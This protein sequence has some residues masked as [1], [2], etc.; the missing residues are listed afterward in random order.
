[1]KRIT[2]YN[3]EGRALHRYNGDNYYP[4]QTSD[5]RIFRIMDGS[6][7]VGIFDAEQVFMISEG[8]IVSEQENDSFNP[9][10]DDNAD[11]IANDE[12]NN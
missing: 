1:M 12:M 11:N 4:M 9:T 6:L 2:I 7:V 10:T 8:H 3:Y 5:P